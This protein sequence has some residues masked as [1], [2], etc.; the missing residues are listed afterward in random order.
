MRKKEQDIF[1][2]L[3]LYSSVIDVRKE[4]SFLGEEA[5]DLYQKIKR[6]AKDFSKSYANSIEQLRDDLAKDTAFSSHTQE[7]VSLYGEKIWGR[8][9]NSQVTV[10]GRHDEIP[11]LEWAEESD[12]EKISFYIRC[13]IIRLTVKEFGIASRSSQKNGRLHHVELL[14]E[15]YNA[16]DGSRSSG[17]P[18]VPVAQMLPQIHGTVRPTVER[19]Q[20]SAVT[21]TDPDGNTN[22]DKNIDAPSN[23][24]TNHADGTRPNKRREIYIDE[25]GSNGRL[26]KIC[27]MANVNQQK[28]RECRSMPRSPTAAANRR[29]EGY[30]QQMMIR[31]SNNNADKRSKLRDETA[32][33]ETATIAGGIPNTELGS[34]T[35]SAVV[36]TERDQIIGGHEQDELNVGSSGAY[37]ESPRQ[38]SVIPGDIPSDTQSA[39]AEP[40]ENAH[41]IQHATINS[42]NDNGL[43]LP[44]SVERRTLKTTE[45]R[46]LRMELVKLLLPFLS[47]ID[48][49]NSDTYS[50]EAEER[51]NT[52]LRQLRT[53]DTETLQD[54]L[55]D[56]FTRVHVALESWMNMCHRLAEFR[57]ATGYR[58]QSGAQWEEYLKGLSD[59]PSTRAILRY[60]ELQET[61]LTDDESGYVVETFDEDLAKMFDLLTMVKG[62]TGP[63]AFKG[64]KK[65]NSALLEWF[66]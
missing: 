12:R 8:S 13:W 14:D 63:E 54:K 4:F 48:Q 65:F 20:E 60:L 32:E 1:E 39:V 56:S 2:S 50:V 38:D 47:G 24:S 3:G 28:T 6:I 42:P 31:E 33:T 10:S 46:R 23:I 16:S 25:G 26:P 19:S 62:C 66:K 17:L 40:L 45:E 64:I 49:F 34:P 27:K 43:V 55:G 36:T 18:S 52:L 59:V 35:Q 44:Q 29:C 11:D 37:Q 57:D 7:L 58:G 5:N 9:V 22:T 53:N 51:M 21:H 61:T 41:V 15:D 30:A